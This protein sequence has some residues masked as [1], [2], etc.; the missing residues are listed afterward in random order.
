ME[1]SLKQKILRLRQNGKTYKEIKNELKCSKGTI[2]YHC[3]NSGIE[4][5]NEFR[6]PSKEEIN[7]MQKYYNEHQSSDKTAKHFG[8]SKF[9]ILK[10]VNV[11]S[12]NVLTEQERKQKNIDRSLTFRRNN[13]QKLVDYKG[14]KC[15]ICGYNKCIQAMDFHHKNPLEKRFEL[16][17]MNRTWDILK[18]EVDKCLLVCSNCHREIHA[19]VINIT[20]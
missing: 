20:T 9:T 11:K 13:K 12:R 2:S 7:D 3:K 16:T 10:Y 17:S 8:W 15:E 1:E 5:F 6:S 18:E 4:N 14:G 19:G